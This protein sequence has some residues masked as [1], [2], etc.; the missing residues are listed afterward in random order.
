MSNTVSTNPY[1]SIGKAFMENRPTVV[2]QFWADSYRVRCFLNAYL[3]LT[4][5][6]MMNVM[7]EQML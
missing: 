1:D 5:C 3:T 2:L 6:G 7:V 4:G